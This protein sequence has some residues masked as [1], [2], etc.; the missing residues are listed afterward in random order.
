MYLHDILVKF[1]A[2]R[3]CLQNTNHQQQAHQFGHFLT[4]QQRLVEML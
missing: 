2:L 3:N 4:I 1:K